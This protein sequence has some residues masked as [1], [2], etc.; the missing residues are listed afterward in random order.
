MTDYHNLATIIAEDIEK[1]FNEARVEQRYRNGEYTLSDIKE[2]IEEYIRGFVEVYNQRRPEEELK[3]EA[4]I[5]IV[6]A[7]LVR[8]EDN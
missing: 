6:R 2:I 3:L 1:L 4:L 8:G 5:P 7:K